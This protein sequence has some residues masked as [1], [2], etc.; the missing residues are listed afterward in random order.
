[1]GHY[2]H[3]DSDC[4]TKNQSNTHHAEMASEMLSI[5]QNTQSFAKLIRLEV[6]SD[7]CVVQL[8]TKYLA[9][10]R[11]AFLGLIRFVEYESLRPHISQDD[12]KVII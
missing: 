2:E 9:K 4:H 11:P 5:F 3:A 8:A 6:V 7:C 12:S 1:M 10:V